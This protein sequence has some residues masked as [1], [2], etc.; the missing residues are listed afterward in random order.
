MTGHVPAARNDECQ[1]VVAPLLAAITLHPTG[2]GIAVVSNLLWQV[3]RKYWGSNAHLATIFDHESRPAT[4]RE[5]AL[6]TMAVGR[7]QLGGGTDWILFSHLRLAQAQ[8]FV[9]VRRRRPYG[10]FLH[11][12]EAWE[13]LTARE[14]NAVAAADVR[15]ANSRYTASRV[16]ALHPDVGHVDVCPLALPPETNGGVRDAGMDIGIELTRHAILVVG[17]MSQS[18]R[19]KGHDQLIDAWPAVVGRLPDAQLIIVGDGDDVPRLKRKARETT[20]GDRIIF[21]GFVSA[22]TLDTLYKRSA[23]FALPSGGEGFGLVYLEAMAHR[24]P[25]VGSVRDAASEIIVDGHTGRLVEQDNVA[26]LSDTLAAL[27]LDEPRRH[28]MGEAGY[29]RAATEFSFDRFSSRVCTL[30]N[31]AERRRQGSPH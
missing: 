21:T 10:V 18:E 31:E 22:S 17:R 20:G 5:K 26:G 14:K 19:Y 15:I 16:M 29:R 3:F 6:F 23:L 2:G 12:I 25:C 30:L 24:L 11:G 28:G 27:L 1:D 7:A 9:P 8:R 4:F 13:R